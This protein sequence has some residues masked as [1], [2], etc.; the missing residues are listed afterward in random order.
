MP[1]PLS[2]L[3]TLLCSCSRCATSGCR[4]R[5]MN[6]LVMLIPELILSGMSLVLLLVARRIQRTRLAAAATVLAALAAALASIWILSQGRNIAFG[7]M[8]VL[9]GYS[10]FF[11]VLIAATLALAALLSVRNPFEAPRSEEHTSELQSP[12]N[13]VCRLLLEKKKKH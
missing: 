9:D 13:L 1:R 11:K 3:R 12:C 4:S 10:Q 6:D 7:G 8:L 5:A 2:G